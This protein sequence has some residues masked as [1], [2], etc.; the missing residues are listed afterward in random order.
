MTYVND[1][2]FSDC[3]IPTAYKCE[4]SISQNYTKPEK[5]YIHQNVTY[6]KGSNNMHEYS[7]YN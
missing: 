7:E 3:F 5:K 2:L 4:M 6:L 1:N